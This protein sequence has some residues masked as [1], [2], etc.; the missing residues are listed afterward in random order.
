MY[1]LFLIL[2][3]IQSVHSSSFA[4]EQKDYK[5]L[6]YE[7]NSIGIT[8]LN[9]F[10]EEN[11]LEQYQPKPGPYDH[12]PK[13]W[14]RG[15]DKSKTVK[16]TDG[17]IRREDT[18]IPS[19]FNEDKK[20][21]ALFVVVHGT[22][23]STSSGYFDDS[24]SESNYV[25]MKNFAADYAEKQG[26]A[27]HFAS[28][29]WSGN[30]SDM[31]RGTSA[32]ALARYLNSATRD[33]LNN[34]DKPKKRV[35]LMS[36][37]HG[38]NMLS[39]VTYQLEKEAE[40][41]VYFACPVRRNY[42]QNIPN[43]E[44]FKKLVYFHS[45]YDWTARAG[46]IHEENLMKR[47]GVVFTAALTGYLAVKYGLGNHAES[48]MNTV[49]N[50]AVDSTWADDISKM[51]PTLP[52]SPE[53]F[54]LMVVNSLYN[55]RYK[56]SINIRQNYTYSGLF[57]GGIVLLKNA[58]SLIKPPDAS[59]NIFPFQL[60]KDIVGIHS[61][62]DGKQVWHTDVTNMSQFLPQIMDK[63]ETGIPCKAYRLRQ[64]ECDTS[65]YATDPMG[66]VVLTYDSKHHIPGFDSEQLS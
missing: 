14:K 20:E 19:T 45:D 18:Y 3:L 17:F 31:S 41:L 65:L 11:G 43:P 25:H 21:E 66:S 62:I 9:G 8:N 36:H 46:R 63:L 44:K 39:Q 60:N 35:I 32:V 2:S 50:E 42:A 54:K 26:I 64:A 23:G 5:R 58:L 27:V 49:I 38:G 57:T 52:I 59:H 61:K 53:K 30:L 1:F 16:E 13:E 56:E 51:V 37:S 15:F 47:V 4:M 6:C 22:W 33:D 55:H 48:T 40:L 10:Y 28:F 24:F 7:Q 12:L 29:Q 34:P